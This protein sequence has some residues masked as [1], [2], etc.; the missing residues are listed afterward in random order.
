[1]IQ[2]I[3][4]LVLAVTLAGAPAAAQSRP[5]GQ[6]ADR[7]PR[8]T[9]PRRTIEPG[10][11]AHHLQ[12]LLYTKVTVSFDH[13]RVRDVIT[14]LKDRLGITIIARYSDDRIGFGI[15]P[16]TPI[17]F[18]AED[19]PA[20]ILLEAILDQCADVDDCTWQLRRGYVEVGTKERLGLPPARELRTYSIESLLFEAPRF[21]D[22]PRVDLISAYSWG[23]EWRSHDRY[24][25]LGGGYGGAGGYG[26]TIAPGGRNS[27]SD[28][29]R[30][31]EKAQ[32]VIDLITQTVDPGGW[33]R[34]GGDWANIRYF[35]GLIVV[36]APDF[37][38]RQ[39]N[40][41]PLIPPPPE[42][43]DAKEAPQAPPPGSGP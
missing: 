37:V 36:K 18:E 40:G 30:R 24:G 17:T 14:Y 1:M 13:T 41:Y 31:Q 26:G 19:M 10:S 20:V 23:N 25:V 16:E 35:D 9:L 15:D 3:L 5:A 6:A 22:A 12:V 43:A 2:R 28:E 38:H 34:N 7:P 27:I 33:S 4:F 8:V 29:A 42:A 32:E 39:I 11:Q 21:D